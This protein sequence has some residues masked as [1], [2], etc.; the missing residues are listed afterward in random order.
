MSVTEPRLQADV[1]DPSAEAIEKER[2]ASRS[3]L[4]R[5]LQA[6]CR[7]PSAGTGSELDVLLREGLT[8]SG[9]TPTKAGRALLEQALEDAPTQHHTTYLA[10]VVDA[11]LFIRAGGNTEVFTEALDPDQPNTKTVV[12]VLVDR[13]VEDFWTVAGDLP[14]RALGRGNDA[15]RMLDMVDAVAFLSLSC[16]ARDEQLWRSRLHECLSTLITQREKNIADLISKLQRPA[17]K[18][19]VQMHLS[20]DNAVD[21]VSRALFTAGEGGRFSG[22]Y[23]Q[24]FED[25]PELRRL[26]KLRI[27]SALN[28]VGQREQRRGGVGRGAALAIDGGADRDDRTWT[29][30]DLEASSYKSAS[31]PD[32]DWIAHHAPEAVASLFRVTVRIANA[33]S[34]VLPAGIGPSDRLLRWLVGVVSG[35]P[36]LGLVVPRNG[37]RDE[38]HAEERIDTTD[39]V[40]VV[41]AWISVFTTLGIATGWDPQIA[42]ADAVSVVAEWIASVNDVCMDEK[43]SQ[44][45]Q[46]VVIM[47]KVTES[48]P[49]D[50]VRTVVDPVRMNHV[51]VVERLRGM[52]GYSNIGVPSALRKQKQRI[53]EVDALEALV[54][55]VTGGDDQQETNHG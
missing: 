16:A 22:V 40:K 26:A 34:E 44:S 19:A 43:L 20:D 13:L 31:M 17:R 7:V 9:R 18:I 14:D 45:E 39:V 53:I 15:D 12:D 48:G 50:T 54:D 1:A 28:R 55:H 21:A 49:M 52:D 10:N 37:I 27:K 2:R 3:A 46:D 23:P 33:P 5:N 47:K 30:S 4:R 41:E 36:A 8:S 51:R 38:V 32:A 11:M 6:L 24:A 35:D 42:R 25:T 29:I